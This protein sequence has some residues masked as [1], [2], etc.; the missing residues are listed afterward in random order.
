MQPITECREVNGPY[1]HGFLRRTTIG[2]ARN[3]ALA[4]A[5]AEFCRQHELSLCGLFTERETPGEAHSRAFAGLL[6]VLALPDAYGVVLPS[7]SHLGPGHLA[8]GRER[9]IQALSSRL[10]VIRSVAPRRSNGHPI[11]PDPIVRQRSGA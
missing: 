6:D 9:Q 7:L 11:E 8:A 1:V 3:T 10:L 2:G 5:L 4:V